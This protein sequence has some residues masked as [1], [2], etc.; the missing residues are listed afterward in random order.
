[1]EK[2]LK[3]YLDQESDIIYDISALVSTGSV[4]M[5]IPEDVLLNST[6]IETSTG[7]VY[8]QAEDNIIFYGNL[9]LTAS[10]GSIDL[11]AKGT[12]FTHGFIYQ[13]W[14]IY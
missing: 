5:N 10:T 6:D 11:F 7:S 8:V 2:I 1:M 9:D 13:I 4:E 12:N 3:L 14:S